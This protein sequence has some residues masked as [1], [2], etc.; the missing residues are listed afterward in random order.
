MTKTG[1]KRHARHGKA[2]VGPGR[3]PRPSTR[4]R[5]QI[6]VDVTLLTKAM[7]VTGLNQSD[8]VNE[9]LAQI[10]ENAAIMEGLEQLHGAFP[11]HPRHS[12][13]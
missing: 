10:G 11:D 3:P 5:K 9:A 4:Q 13:G 12:D 1:T 6:I 7:Q 2:S 8:T